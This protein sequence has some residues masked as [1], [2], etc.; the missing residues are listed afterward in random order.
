MHIAGGSYLESC[1]EPH[2]S[3]LYGSGGRAAAALAWRAERVTLST[4][5]SE[6][7]LPSL[8]CLAATYGFESCTKT[9]PYTVAFHYNHPLSVP[10]IWPTIDPKRKLA[11]LEVND[12]VVL[13]FGFIE[14]DA[15]VHGSYVTYDPQSAFGPASFSLNGSSADH[16]AIVCNASEARKL[17]GANSAVEAARRLI[18]DA[19]VVVVKQGSQGAIVQTAN[20]S[21]RVPAY[22]TSRV[23]PLG[24]GDI[25][26]AV[27]AHEWGE[28]LRDPSEA[29]DLASRATAFYCETQTLPVPLKEDLSDYGPLKSSMKKDAAS[30]VYLAGPFFTTAQRWLVAELRT[31]LGHQG[32][33]V[34]SPLHDVGH[35]VADDVVPQ[36]IEAIRSSS[37]LLAILDG[38]DAG[39]LFE[40][41][42]ARALG[43]PVVGFVQSEG[44]EAMKMLRGTGCSLTDDFATAV[45]HTAWVADG[46]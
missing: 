35:G 25:F 23:W 12:D 42:Y 10:E 8:E 40:V 15:I 32:L 9:A 43:I 19:D 20:E 41:G 39:T 17:S 37:A 1:D 22:R 5:V 29:A 46:E 11:P 21:I 18:R 28:N 44:E 34:F 24:S 33:N 13:R 7:Q 16:L 26:A 45:Y 30:R 4:Y 27:F 6:Q 36:D 31:S 38:Q 2:W 3:Q 14:G